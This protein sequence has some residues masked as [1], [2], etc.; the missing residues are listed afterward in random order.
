MVQWDTQNRGRS[1]ES[2]FTTSYGEEN[3]QGDYDGLSD[4]DFPGLPL[5]RLRGDVESVGVDSD[6]DD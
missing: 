5:V 6:Y 2:Q 3:S 4:A 1:R